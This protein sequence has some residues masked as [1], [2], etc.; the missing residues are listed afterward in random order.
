MRCVNIADMAVETA[1]TRLG[2]I[3]AGLVLVGLVTPVV[4]RGTRRRTG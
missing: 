4:R 2:Q 1:R 3:V